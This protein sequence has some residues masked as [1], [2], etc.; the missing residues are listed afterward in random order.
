MVTRDELREVADTVIS[1]WMLNMTP[2]QRKGFYRTWW[3]YLYDLDVAAVFGVVDELVLA[4]RRDAP[5]PGAVRLQ[6][7]SSGH[8]SADEAWGLV[9][10]RLR[11]LETGAEGPSIPPTVSAAMRAVGLNGRSKPD[12]FAFREAYKES[13]ARE[14]AARYVPP[15]IEE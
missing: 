6:V 9:Q 2:E 1:A 15:V 4:N 14:L 3:R 5:R 8:L 10:E 13:V 12:G 11:C 7:L